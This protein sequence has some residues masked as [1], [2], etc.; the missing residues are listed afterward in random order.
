VPE[1]WEYSG[2]TIDE[3]VAQEDKVRTDMLVVRLVGGLSLKNG[4]SLSEAERR[5][6]AVEEMEDDVN[7]GGYLSLFENAPER[8]PGLVEALRDIGCPATA[9]ITAKAIAALGIEGSLTAEA[10]ADAVMRLDE[11]AESALDGCD[12][13]YFASGEDI[14]GRLFEWIKANRTKIAIP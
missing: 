11:Q 5:V 6:L 7:G 8:V 12:Q 14:A 1:E 10:I 9:S 13:E 2:E 3:L 4:D